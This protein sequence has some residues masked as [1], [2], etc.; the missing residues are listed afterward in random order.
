V[1]TANTTSEIDALEVRYF[2]MHHTAKAL[3]RQLE[4]DVERT[5]V[6][7]T[8]SM[9]EQLASTEREMRS[10]LQEITLLEARLVDS[11]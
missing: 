8:Q 2:E 11:N 3:R 10:I 5:E 1:S 4:G 7:S 9:K 6:G